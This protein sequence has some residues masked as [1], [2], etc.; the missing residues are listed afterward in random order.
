MMCL[1]N[2]VSR[3]TC[4][5]RFD[6]TNT[7]ETLALSHVCSTEVAASPRVPR[8]C[9]VVYWTAA[10]YF[11]YRAAPPLRSTRIVSDKLPVDPP[12]DSPVARND[13]RAMICENKASI[14]R[15]L[16]HRIRKRTAVL[17]TARI[18]HD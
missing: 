6:S 2:Y 13:V 11:P 4:H 16:G 7:L 9:S 10:G 15:E 8:C 3:K 1:L 18:T 14:A 12:P 5:L 17:P